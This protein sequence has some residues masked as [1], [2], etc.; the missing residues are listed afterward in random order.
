M[1][2]PDD[3]FHKLK[4]IDQ[5]A[6]KLQWAAATAVQNATWRFL[7]GSGNV[8]VLSQR[9][10]QTVIIAALARRAIVIT[11]AVFCLLRAGLLEGAFALS[12]TLLEIHFTLKLVMS[13]DTSKMALR[14]LGYDCYQRHLYGEKQLR[15]PVTR[16][17]LEKHKG[18]KDNVAAKAKSWRDTLEDKA[19]DNVREELLA[20]LKNRKGWHGKGQQIA[21][22]A[23]AADMEEDYVR[24]YSLASMYVHAINVAWDFDEQVDGKPMLKAFVRE[25]T[26]DIVGTLGSVTIELL[27]ILMMLADYRAEDLTRDNKFEAVA[28]QLTALT[29][30]VNDAFRGVVAKPLA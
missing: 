5:S 7:L 3:P 19:F 22:A 11:E 9:H 30:F 20:D 18:E 15:S 29:N 26:N 2:D 12:R 1:T 6:L 28:K 21:D 17:M 27:Y 10:Q 23:K 13:D 8:S 16:K 24:S 4:P 25:D 14:L